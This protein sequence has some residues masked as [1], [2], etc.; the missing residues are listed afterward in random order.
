MDLKEHHN[1]VYSFDSGARYLHYGSF[2][3]ENTVAEQNWTD[4]NWMDLIWTELKR[5]SFDTN[6]FELNN[7]GVTL[8]LHGFPYSL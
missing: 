8:M 1:T 4:L 6:M 2:F 7:S 5:Q 3:D